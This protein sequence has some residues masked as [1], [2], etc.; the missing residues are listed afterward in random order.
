[1][2]VLES[3]F[4][5]TW[6]LSESQKITKKSP[7]QFSE[8][9]FPSEKGLILLSRYKLSRGTNFSGDKLSWSL[10]RAKWNLPIGISKGSL[11]NLWVSFW[12]EFVFGKHQNVKNTTKRA[13]SSTGVFATHAWGLSFIVPGILI[14]T[15]G[16]LN[17]IFLIPDPSHINITLEK[18]VTKKLHGV[19]GTRYESSR[20]FSASIDSSRSTE[21]C[22]SEVSGLGDTMDTVAPSAVG[23]LSALRIPGVVEYSLCLFFA[24]LVSYTFLFWLPFYISA[25]PIDGESNVSYTLSVKK[26]LSVKKSDFFSRVKI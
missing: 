6:F 12:T 1:M 7:A 13:L 3:I 18:P 4:R 9:F 26:E 14:T 22:R 10:F 19:G 23:L 5:L 2:Y 8:R 21:S 24:K 16:I 25:T 20:Q 15:V 11:N 17:Y